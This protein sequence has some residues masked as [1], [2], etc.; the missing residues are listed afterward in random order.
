MWAV[1][2]LIGFISFV[3]GDS[4][5]SLTLRTGD[6]YPYVLLRRR[7]LLTTKESFHVSYWDTGRQVRPVSGV[8]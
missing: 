2:P 6:G 1:P 5:T 3:H 4:Y 7:H 8:S